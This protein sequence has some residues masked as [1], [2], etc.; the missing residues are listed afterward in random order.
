MEDLG[1]PFWTATENIC[2]TLRQDSQ[3]HRFLSIVLPILSWIKL[4]VGSMTW[5]YTFW[6]FNC[7]GQWPIPTREKWWFSRQQST[8]GYTV[9]LLPLKASCTAARSSSLCLK[10]RR[11]TPKIAWY[12]SIMFVISYQIISNHITSYLSC[13][14]TSYLT[15]FFHNFIMVSPY[16]SHWW[17]A[18]PS[19]AGSIWTLGRLA[20]YRSFRIMPA[21]FGSLAA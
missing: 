9:R 13:F 21:A 10:I 20:E 3:P 2:I 6:S 1:Y 15:C 18:W 8:Q 11:N 4:T 19:A 14:S 7:Y 16:V 5:V 12:L 17:A